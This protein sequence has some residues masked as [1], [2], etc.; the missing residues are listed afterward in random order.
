VGMNLKLTPQKKQEFLLALADNPNVT[1]AAEKINIS[2]VCLYDERKKDDV[3]AADWEVAVEI[4]IQALEDEAQRRAF[5]GTLK[6]SKFGAFKE[7]SDTLAIFLLK[8]YNPNKFNPPIRNE[9]TGAN[10]QPLTP[11][12]DDQIAVKLAA[13]MRAA[14]ARKAA[15]ENPEQVIDDSDGEDDEDFSDM[16]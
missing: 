7:Y 6:L 9:L 2:R 3:F 15:Q 16:V 4:G 1:K 5:E 8:A 12:G 11:L 10:G 14:M 13:I